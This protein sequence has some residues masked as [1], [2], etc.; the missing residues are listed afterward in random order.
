MA[1]E[2]KIPLDVL[3]THCRGVDRLS[4]PRKRQKMGYIR[5]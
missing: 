5:R 1:V 3:T 4:V 2:S